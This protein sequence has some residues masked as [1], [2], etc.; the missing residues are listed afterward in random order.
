VKAD[1]DR[2]TGGIQH[3]TGGPHNKKLS[4]RTESTCYLKI[5]VTGLLK[6]HLYDG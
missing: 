5:R 2:R 3:S 6:V 4:S 1:T